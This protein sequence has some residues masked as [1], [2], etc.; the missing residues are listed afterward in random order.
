M[1]TKDCYNPDWGCL[2]DFLC[3]PGLKNCWTHNLRSYFS[4]SGAYDLSATATP[5]SQQYFP[6]VFTCCISLIE[7][8]YFALSLNVAVKNYLWG[9]TLRALFF[10]SFILALYSQT[11]VKIFVW[12][13]SLLLLGRK[14][15]VLFWEDK[16]PFVWSEYS[17]REKVKRNDAIKQLRSLWILLGGRKLWN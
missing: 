9:F 3:N 17:M 5:S 15:L 8:F 10:A 1:V 11:W 7:S 2:V 16:A 12:V 14:F 6:T 4:Q 13:K